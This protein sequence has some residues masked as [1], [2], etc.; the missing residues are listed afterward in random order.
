MKPRQDA[1]SFASPA[2]RSSVTGAEFAVDDA[3][4]FQ[5]APAFG[6]HPGGDFGDGGS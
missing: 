3:G 5:F 1:A 6:V 4:R 2:R